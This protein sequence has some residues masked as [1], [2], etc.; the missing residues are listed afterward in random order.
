MCR[1]SVDDTKILMCLACDLSDQNLLVFF[2][3]PC[4]VPP[5]VPKIDLVF[6]ISSVSSSADEVFQ[7]TQ[8]AVT[9]IIEKYG[10]NDI[11]YAVILF[12]SDAQAVINFDSYTTSEQLN[13]I[14]SNLR[15]LKG[16]PVLDKALKLAGKVLTSPQARSDAHKV[17]VVITDKKASARLDDVILEENMLEDMEVTVIPVGI[18]A[19]TDRKELEELTPDVTDV[20]TTS[21]VDDPDELGR[22][23]M[24]RVLKGIGRTLYFGIACRTPDVVCFIGIVYY[25]WIDAMFIMVVLNMIN[26]LLE[27]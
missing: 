1:I 13:A 20:F 11:H 8:N 9:Y 24:D 7:N 25:M 6:A 19:E 4:L 17:L 14:L 12:G 26:A 18:G 23:I 15:R 22:N 3:S 10:T 5:M 16:G 27:N 2:F 21:K